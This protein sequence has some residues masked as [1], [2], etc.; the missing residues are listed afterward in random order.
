MSGNVH[1]KNGVFL[2]HI[3]EP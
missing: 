3:K 2:A 1:R